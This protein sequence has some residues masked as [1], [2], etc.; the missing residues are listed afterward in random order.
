MNVYVQMCALN[1]ILYAMLYSNV[2]KFKSVFYIWVPTYI[3]SIVLNRIRYRGELKYT[4][5]KKTRMGYVQA[6]CIKL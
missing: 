2:G 5:V 6:V 1:K 3:H 4:F